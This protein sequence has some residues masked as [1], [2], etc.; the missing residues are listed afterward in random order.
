MM[1]PLTVCN[2]SWDRV[3]KKKPSPSHNNSVCM[4]TLCFLQKDRQIQN[5][6]LL[7][8]LQRSGAPFRAPPRNL[9]EQHNHRLWR[10]PYCSEGSLRPGINSRHK[11]NSYRAILSL[12]IPPLLALWQKRAQILIVG[13]LQN[14]LP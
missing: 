11:F 4:S 8:G 9:V 3:Q 14:P 10:R 7:S 1:S 5:D 2:L 6:P 13:R 12:P